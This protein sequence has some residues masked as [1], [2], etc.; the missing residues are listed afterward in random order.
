MMG[1]GWD[2]SETEKPQ[3]EGFQPLSRVLNLLYLGHEAHVLR[4]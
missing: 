3:Q 4:S 2:L 1:E